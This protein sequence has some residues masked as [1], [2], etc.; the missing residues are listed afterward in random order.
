MSAIAS[1]EGRWGY[2]DVALELMHTDAS[3]PR[4]SPARS[5]EW[6]RS[7]AAD[8]VEW[9]G[10]RGTTSNGVS[11]PLRPGRDNFDIE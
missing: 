8:R 3:V 9:D 6:Q 10:A 7:S 5:A 11:T 4:A 2:T 1:N